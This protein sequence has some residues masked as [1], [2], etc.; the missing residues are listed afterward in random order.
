MIVVLGT[1][2]DRWKHTF[3]TPYVGDHLADALVSILRS[4][5]PGKAAN[6]TISGK[7]TL[8]RNGPIGHVGSKWV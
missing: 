5:T 7:A 6:I 1:T 3:I 8:E 2:R 4:G